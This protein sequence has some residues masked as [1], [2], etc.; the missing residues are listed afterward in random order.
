MMRGS[1]GMKSGGEGGGIEASQ[2][3]KGRG[4]GGL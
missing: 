3:G 2:R 1:E 4:E